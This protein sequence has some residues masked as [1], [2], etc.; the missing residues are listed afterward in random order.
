MENISKNKRKIHFRGGRMKMIDEKTTKEPENTKKEE[1][2]TELEK[3][4]NSKPNVIFSPGDNIFEEYTIIDPLNI[5][6]GEADLYQVKKDENI[7][8]LKLYRFGYTPK[9]EIYKKL[10]KLYNSA[11]ENFLHIIKYGFIDSLKRHYEIQ[12]YIPLNLSDFIKKSGKIEPDTAKNILDKLTQAIHA[13]HQEDII[14]RDIKPSNILIRNTNPP[15]PIIADIGIASVIEPGESRRYHTSVRR[16]LMYSPPESKTG[17]IGKEV[18]YWALGIIMLEIISGKHPYEG[19][20]SEIID[21]YL[22]IKPVP[23]SEDI[24]PEWE[25]LIK[26]LLTRNLKKRWGFEQIMAWQKGEKDIPVYF[27]GG[28]EI[29]SAYSANRVPLTIFGKAIFTLEELTNF[30]VSSPKNWEEACK[31]LMRGKI[32]GWIQWEVKDEKLASVVDDIREE[33]NVSVDLLLFRTIYKMNP[34]AHFAFKGKLLGRKTPWNFNNLVKLLRDYYESLNDSSKDLKDLMNYILNEKLFSQYLKLLPENPDDPKGDKEKIDSIVRLENS[35]LKIKDLPRKI[36]TY[37]LA[38]TGEKEQIVKNIKRNLNEKIY[39]E[40]KDFSIAQSIVYKE[41]NID[42]E[43][44]MKIKKFTDNSGYLVDDL[45]KLFN[46]QFKTYLRWIFEKKQSDEDQII[47]DI[48]Y[49]KLYSQYLKYLKRPTKEIEKIE[50]I[51][52]LLTE[53]EK[54]YEK[55]LVYYIL[56]YDAFEEIKQGVLKKYDNKLIDN[57]EMDT[58][59][60]EFRKNN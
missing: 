16:T 49:N 10:E 54:N 51:E 52:K 53:Y 1:P 25:R 44:L 19:L 59:L 6:S 35:I 46:D 13:L 43:L 23:I 55:A 24:N 30:I 48:F 2:Q 39:P 7:Y 31:F 32:S 42:G 50:E 18:D 17:I 36:I 28:E 14:H 29:M 38:L 58:I 3:S 20:K 15:I 22:T 26:G 34:S 9:K 12:E 11:S 47:L 4:N 57:D 33:E 41:D 60:N 21:Y 8:I 45:K 56:E 27:E 5:S 37:I 40:S